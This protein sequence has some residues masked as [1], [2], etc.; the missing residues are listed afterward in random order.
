MEID[1]IPYFDGFSQEMRGFAR[2]AG[3]RCSFFMPNPLRSLDQAKDSLPQETRTNAVYSVTSKT[4]DAEYIEETK[5]VRKSTEMQ[6][7]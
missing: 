2:M 6:S 3:L 7:V 5:R 1:R 4:C